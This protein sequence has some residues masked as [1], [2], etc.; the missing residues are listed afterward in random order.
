MNLSTLG[1]GGIIAVIV[2]VVDAV[3][4]LLGRPPG[5]PEVATLVGLL[6]VARLT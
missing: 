6:A 2:L 1:L 5:G 4:A 3:L